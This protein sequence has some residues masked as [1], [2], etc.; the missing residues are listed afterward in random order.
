MPVLAPDIHRRAVNGIP[1]LDDQDSAGTRRG[2]LCI[3]RKSVLIP[4]MR[5]HGHTG[6]LTYTSWRAMLARCSQPSHRSYR[7]Y[8]GKGIRVDP[9][10]RSFQ[11]FLSDLGPRPSPAHTLGR[12]DHARPYEPSNV[13]WATR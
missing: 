9:R 11:A 12:R 2:R 10:W 5:T 7:Y 3:R 4:V 13:G 6:S 8:G 1:K